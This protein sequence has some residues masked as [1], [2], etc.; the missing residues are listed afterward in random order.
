MCAG[1]QQSSCDPDS[2]LNKELNKCAISMFPPHLL[3]CRIL[4]F[5]PTP[6]LTTATRLGSQLGRE[7]LDKGDD[8]RGGMEGE[9]QF[10][11]VGLNN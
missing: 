6:T 5:A 9:R 4:S 11:F 10:L 8:K 2:F 7:R 3:T 1:R